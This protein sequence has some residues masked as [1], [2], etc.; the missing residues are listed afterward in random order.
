MA[1]E[2][3]R[4]FRRAIESYEQCLEIDPNHH[5]AA[6]NI[7]EAYRKNERY[8]EAIQAYDYALTL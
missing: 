1:Y 3:D 2:D 7:G 4:Q 8:D 5:Q 6:T